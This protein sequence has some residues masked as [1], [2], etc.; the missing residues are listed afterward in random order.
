[1]RLYYI[2]IFKCNTINSIISFLRFI[3]LQFYYYILSFLKWFVYYILPNMQKSVR[4]KIGYLLTASNSYGSFSHRYYIEWYSSLA[5]QN[6]TLRF[7][8]KSRIDHLRDN[9]IESNKQKR[10][11]ILPIS[12][13]L[14]SRSEHASMK[15]RGES[16]A[17]NGMFINH[18]EHERKFADLWSNHHLS[19]S[20]A[21][22][23]YREDRIA[24]LLIRT[25]E[26]SVR[27]SMHR[28]SSYVMENHR[29]HDHQMKENFIKK[30]Q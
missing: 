26:S 24:F 12:F 8:Q 6:M 2:H 21:W 15:E 4:H 1:M 17:R 18:V 25:C 27:R 14:T 7:T 3:F 16:F 13:H 19:W 22:K 28:V 11:C 20:I 9:K 30:I 29:H 23:S 10:K 5:W